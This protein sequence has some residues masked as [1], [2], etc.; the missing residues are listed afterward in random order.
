MV[1]KFDELRA[2]REEITGL[3]EV[4]KALMIRRRKAEADLG[5]AETEL[6][7]LRKLEGFVNIEVERKVK[8]LREL[9]AKQE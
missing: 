1:T 2:L 4:Q 7:S 9:E 8:V 3:S 5:Q 6:L